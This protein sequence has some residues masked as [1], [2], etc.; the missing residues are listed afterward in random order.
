MNRYII[1]YFCNDQSTFFWIE[2]V[3]FENLQNELKQLYF[4]NINIDDIKVFKYKQVNVK[5]EISAR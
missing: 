2:N 4:R 5:L 3:L 1:K